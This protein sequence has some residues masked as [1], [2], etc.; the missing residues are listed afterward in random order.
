MLYMVIMVY[1]LNQQ[2]FNPITMKNIYPKMNA[3]GA[4]I[5]NQLLGGIANAEVA[6]WHF[7]DNDHGKNAFVP[8]DQFKLLFGYDHEIIPNLTASTQLLLERTL[9]YQTV[10]QA[11]E[12]LSLHML[13][14]WHKTLTLRLTYLALQ[15]KLTLSVFNFYSPDSK[16][17]YIR[18]KVS[19]RYNDNMFYEIGANM[20]GGKNIYTQWG[21]FKEDSN[22]YIRFK[23][24]F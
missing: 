8:A 17:F 18:P 9:N 4:S 14:K 21:Q 23:Y 24:N 2:G 5:R 12:R 3:T 16:D 22:I 1:I 11:K 15:Q 13:D 6:Y 20:F 19:Y 7:L 10:K